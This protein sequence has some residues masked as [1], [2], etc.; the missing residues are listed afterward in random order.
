MAHVKYLIKEYASVMSS[1]N[2]RVIRVSFEVS[3]C[4]KKT[5]VAMAMLIFCALI[6]LK[7]YNRLTRHLNVDMTLATK[8]NNTF[9]S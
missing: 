6:Y 1:L 9:N 3:L 4:Y 2:L 8:I 7:I 5:H